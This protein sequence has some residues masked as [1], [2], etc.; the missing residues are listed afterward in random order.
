MKSP[1]IASLLLACSMV[2]C[3]PYVAPPPPGT[4][5]SDHVSLPPHPS[6]EPQPPPPAPRPTPRPETQ[7]EKENRL[8]IQLAAALAVKWGVNNSEYEDLGEAIVGGLF[9]L[10]AEAVIADTID[11]ALPE[12][13]PFARRQLVHALCAAAENNLT[14]ESL[15][16]RNGKDEVKAYLDSVDPTLGTSAEVIDFMASAFGRV[17]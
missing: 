11:E 9:D 14:V 6:P 12:V 7:Q 13:D 3:A 1:V 5:R 4:W 17:R 10:G 15:I 2:S 8:A 16:Y